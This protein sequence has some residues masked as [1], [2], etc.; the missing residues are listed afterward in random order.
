MGNFM[1]HSG[2]LRRV[3]H[4]QRVACSFEVTLKGK[5]NPAS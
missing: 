5:H 4:A 2:R 1:K 3:V